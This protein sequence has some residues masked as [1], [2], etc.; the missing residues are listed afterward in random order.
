MKKYL[1]FEK[2]SNINSTNK[3]IEI[4]FTKKDLYIIVIGLIFAIFL[5]VL[6]I[7]IVIIGI[8]IVN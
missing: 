8:Y 6:D 4:L 3:E 2:F 7:T 1:F 5:P